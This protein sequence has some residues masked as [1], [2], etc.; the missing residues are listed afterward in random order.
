MIYRPALTDKELTQ[1]LELQARNLRPLL[2]RDTVKREGFVTLRH[3]LDMLQKM[4]AMAP[5]FIAFD[6][7]QVQ[8]YALCLH[9]AIQEIVPDLAPMFNCIEAALK[10]GSEYRV[11]GQVCIAR[12]F[13]RQGHFRELYHAL[14]TACSPLPLITEIASDN[15]RSL[16]AHFA[17]GFTEL[18]THQEGDTLWHVVILNSPS[19]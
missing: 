15:P 13:R 11:M 16:G 12:D 4:Q 3:S 8:G 6:G 14:S 2:D 5:Q 9:P 10:P 7:L 17:V 1:I 18:T 19:K